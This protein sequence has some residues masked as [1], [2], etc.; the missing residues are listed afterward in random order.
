MLSEM[1][2]K[3]S[4]AV[5]LYDQL[6]TDQIAHPTWRAASTSQQP[7]NHV[8]SRYHT[9]DGSTRSE[10]G[11]W[12]RQ[13]SIGSPQLVKQGYQTI[14]HH[15]DLS[16][17]PTQNHSPPQH[18]PLY[19]SELGTA[20]SYHSSAPPVQAP[21]AYQQS[22]GAPAIGTSF[23]ESYAQQ[24]PWTQTT[25]ETTASHL[26]QQVYQTPIPAPERWPQNQENQSQ[27]HLVGQVPRVPMEQP[28]SYSHLQQTPTSPPAIQHLPVSPPPVAHQQY[29]SKAP[30]PIP[31]PAQQQQSYR[32]AP[33][34]STLSR[35]S[36][37]SHSTYAPSAIPSSSTTLGRS[38]TI[39]S[40]SQPQQVYA[41]PPG[42]SN[43]LPAFPTAPTSNPQLY[44]LYSPPTTG[45]EETKKE[46]TLI[47]L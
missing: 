37:L 31:S 21:D 5:R 12:S 38:N 13:E 30:L 46:V 18:Q 47:D 19:V 22:S 20:S 1:H 28:Q 42:T 7:Y 24:P 27:H 10:L 36:T 9:V 32:Q 14:G 29:A 6:L 35:H 2:D 23:H 33:L 45:F 8:A 3:L 17:P 44:P 34:P 41:P 39:A 25:G 11:E 16:P 40:H 4:H 43:P 15:P 26:S